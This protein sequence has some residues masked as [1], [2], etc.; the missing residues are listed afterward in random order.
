MKFNIITLF[1]LLPFLTFGQGNAA[2][3]IGSSLHYTDYT[4]KIIKSEKGRLNYDFNVAMTLPM[5]NKNREWLVGLKFMAYGNKYD[6]GQLKYGSGHDGMGGYN[7][8]IDTLEEV[9]SIQSNSSYYYVELPVG[10]R[11]NLVKTEKSRIFLQASAGPTYFLSAHNNN[12]V[13]LQDGST[14]T[15]VSP[16]NSLNFRTLNLTTGI[17]VGFEFSLKEKLSFQLMPHGQMQVFDIV[18]DSSTHPKWYGFG[19]RGGLR[20]RLL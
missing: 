19:I 7:P 13:T 1:A 14:S 6:S 18:P 10:I 4:N 5:K 9:T 17:A 2:L 16:D 3:E 8:N 12:S 11:Q 15:G 20:Y